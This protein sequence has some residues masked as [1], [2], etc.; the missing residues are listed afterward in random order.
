V[1]VVDNADAIAGPNIK[2]I[3]LL[4][5]TDTAHRVPASVEADQN[6]IVTTFARLPALLGAEAALIARASHLRVECLLGPIDRPFHVAFAAGRIVDM[7]PAPMLMRSWSF[8]YR[9]SLT[10]WGE[11][12]KPAPRPGWHDLLALTKS[13]EAILEGDLLP[14]MTHL[15]YFKDVLALPRA[16]PG[17]TA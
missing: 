3:G 5:E 13:G 16:K 7:A 9:A 15:Q 8:S 17:G 12:W 1:T 11:F 4:E 10:A 6:R 14:F 2:E